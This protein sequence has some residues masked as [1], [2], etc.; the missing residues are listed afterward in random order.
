M[1]GGVAGS[2]RRLLPVAPRPRRH[3]SRVAFDVLRWSIGAVWAVN[4]VF[5][6]DPAN[7]FSQTFPATAASFGPTTFGG[8]EFA[9]LVAANSAIFSLM[10]AAVTVYL[11]VAFLSGTTV[12]AACV[13]GF[14]FNLVLLLTQ[15]G[16]VAVMPVG[17]DVGPQPLYLA[18]D[19]TLLLGM[20]TPALPR[21]WG[22]GL[23]SSLRRP[24]RQRAGAPG[25]LT[26]SP[27]LL[28]LPRTPRS[29]VEGV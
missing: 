11:A 28:P 9:A 27:G 16:S 25:G 29:E 7:R 21:W 8:G 4:S 10:I 13:V 18:I 17:T 19:G 2:S 15:V 22:S 6:L 24:R 12:R 20:E 5:V 23:V 1:T 26:A 3:G 14:C